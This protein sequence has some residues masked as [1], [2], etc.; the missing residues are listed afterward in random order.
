[1]WKRRRIFKA[2]AVALAIALGLAALVWLRPGAAPPVISVTLLGYTNGVG[3]YAVIGISNCSQSAVTL[4]AQCLVQYA[5]IPAG[6]RGRQPVSFE[7]NTLRA[8]R[9]GPCEG[10]VQ[11]IFVFPADRAEWQLEFYASST[12]GWLEMRRSAEA[13]VQKYV[14][15]TKWLRRSKTWNTLHS[16]WFICP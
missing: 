3:P 2:L 7:P 10:F 5:R 12:S 13:W 15:R 1:M 9:L 16:E 4:D 6:P 8:T 11:D 14:L